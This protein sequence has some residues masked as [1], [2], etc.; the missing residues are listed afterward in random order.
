MVIA[1]RSFA[2]GIAA[3]NPA[4]QTFPTSGFI[5]RARDDGGQ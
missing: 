3:I 4:A 5:A 1:D 2:V